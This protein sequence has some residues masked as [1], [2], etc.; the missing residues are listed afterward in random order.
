MKLG[1]LFI[2]NA[3]IAV[4][5]GLALVFIP[6]P[7]MSLFGVTL[8]DGGLFSTRVLGAAY[9]AIAIIS[10][11]VRNSPSSSELRAIVLAFLVSNTISFIIAV[12]YKLQGVSNALGWITVL[13]YLLMGLGFGYFYFVKPK[14]N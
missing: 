14:T 12:I 6:T 2:I 5:F 1:T 13:I 10:W 8:N 11:L 7:M 4:L 3:I 9:L